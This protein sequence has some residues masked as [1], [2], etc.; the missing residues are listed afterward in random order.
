M[1]IDVINMRRSK[2]FLQP[3]KFP[4]NLLRSTKNDFPYVLLKKVVVFA[5]I[6]FLRRLN[7]Y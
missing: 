2:K 1:S 7:N 4:K 6:S 3:K 5:V